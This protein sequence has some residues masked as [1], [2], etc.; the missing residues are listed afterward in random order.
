MIQLLRKPLV[1]VSLH[2]ATGERTTGGKVA[3]S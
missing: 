3:T 2:P 1:D